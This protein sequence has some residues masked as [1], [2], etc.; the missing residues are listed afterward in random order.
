MKTGKLVMGLGVTGRAVVK[1]LLKT[2]SKYETIYAMDSNEKQLVHPEILGF[3]KQG[4]E[5][6]QAT[7]LS[8]LSHV[9]QIILSPGFDPKHSLIQAAHALNIEVIGEIELAFRNTKRPLIGITGTNGK[10]TTTL[11]VA[12][13]L[14]ENGMAA[15]ALGNVGTPLISYVDD[16][17]IGVIE[18]SSYQI[19]TLKSVKLETAA[20]LNITPDHLDRYP[21][22]NHYAKAKY[23]LQHFI[24]PG[25]N[26]ILEEAAAK[27]YP[28]FLE[29][30]A[31]I[32]HWNFP[33][34]HLAE[35]KSHEAE[36]YQ[37]AF[38]LTSQFGINQ[39]QFFNALNSFKKPPHRIEFVRELN[40]I[41]FW[42][43][44]KGTNIDA[45]LRA[46]ETIPGSIHLVVGGVDKGFSYVGWI[47]LFKKK[48][49]SIHVLGEAAE[50]IAKDLLE[51]NS[52]KKVNSLEEAVR[53]AFQFA[54]A[55]EN[56]LLSPGCASFD[57]FKDYI[58]RGDQFKLLVEKLK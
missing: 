30:P 17:S 7:S 24:K 26:F 16:S 47:D 25:G 13:V 9:A 8:S 53:G 57:M 1:Y 10:T 2:K 41:K 56:V 31:T 37:A 58:D 18:L 19:E 43:D 35:T 51:L 46:V 6:L 20:L 23:K 42:N 11:L 44:S 12:H 36:N 52:L 21:S 14:Q 22:M 45:T 28:H 15:Q 29:R 49:K 38:L 32:Y 34:N 5:I 39:K 33:L 50:K 40:G 54:S 48:V 3:I 4:L 55:G 27:N